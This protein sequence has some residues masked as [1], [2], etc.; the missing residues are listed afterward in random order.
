MAAEGFL[1]H[2]LNAPLIVCCLFVGVLLF[3]GLVCLFVC[4]LFVLI[5]VV[6]YCIICTNEDYK[7]EQVIFIYEV[8]L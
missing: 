3:F 6:F 5:A 7:S 2:Y 8:T 4:F 1:S